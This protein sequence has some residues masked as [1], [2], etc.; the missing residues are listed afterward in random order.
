MGA[1]LSSADPREN[2]TNSLRGTNLSFFLEKNWT[3]EIFPIVSHCAR[4]VVL[5]KQV[6]LL[7]LPILMCSSYPFLKQFIYLSTLFQIELICHVACRFCVSMERNEFKM[8]LFHSFVKVF[9]FYLFE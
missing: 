8:F 7:L 4:C 9:D 2:G 6:P 5:V 3:A 1:D